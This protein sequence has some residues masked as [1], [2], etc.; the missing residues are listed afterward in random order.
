MVRSLFKQNYAAYLSKQ[1]D[2]S[3]DELS[4]A[5][6]QSIYVFGVEHD[7]LLN[8][9]A[10]VEELV[11]ALG[12]ADVT[13]RTQSGASLEVSV[14]FPE[15]TLNGQQLSLNLGLGSLVQRAVRGVRL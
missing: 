2:A 1:S 7:F 12:H 14:A 13:I 5:F 8:Q 9:E 15:A 11:V 4:E 10:G 3:S 6:S